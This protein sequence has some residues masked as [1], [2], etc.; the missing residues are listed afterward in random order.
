MS[1]SEYVI[2]NLCSAILGILQKDMDG[3]SSHAHTVPHRDLTWSQL[4]SS[5][6]SEPGIKWGLHFPS[7][8]IPLYNYINIH[9]NI[10]ILNT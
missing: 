7:P 1:G 5:S 4:Q 3:M 8:P 2:Y 6:L 9:K 10:F